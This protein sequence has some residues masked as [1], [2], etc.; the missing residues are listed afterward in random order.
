MSPKCCILLYTL[1]RVY[2]HQQIFL[3]KRWHLVYYKIPIA[4]WKMLCAGNCIA[5]SK[6]NS[7][8][9]LELSVGDTF[10]EYSCWRAVGI[11]SVRGD[12][13]PNSIYRNDSWWNEVI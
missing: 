9:S 10:T 3:P 4:C 6:H 12:A 5:L 2:I 1:S 8:V 13:R 7:R 11:I